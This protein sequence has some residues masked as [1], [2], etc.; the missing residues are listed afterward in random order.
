MA[1]SH[2]IKYALL[3]SL[4]RFIKYGAD[5]LLSVEKATAES[6]NFIREMNIRIADDV[7]TLAFF[8]KMKSLEQHL[9][10]S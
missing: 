3:A 5:I 7:L 4:F 1:E 9:I 2:T 10:A 8:M 6:T